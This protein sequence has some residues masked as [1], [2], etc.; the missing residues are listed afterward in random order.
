M[1]IPKSK[2]DQKL[3]RVLLTYVTTTKT[4]QLRTGE[5]KAD[6]RCPNGKTLSLELF[7]DTSWFK[8]RA[9]W[10]KAIWLKK[11]L[12]SE[13][14]CNATSVCTT[15]SYLFQCNLWPSFQSNG[16]LKKWK[17]PSSLKGCWI[18]GELHWCRESYN[19]LLEWAYGC[20]VIKSWP[21]SVSWWLQL[22]C[23]SSCW[24]H[25]WNGYI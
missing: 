22:I 24:V 23:V 13:V 17:I 7:P 16:T 3:T 6:V 9:H 2:I 18:Q 25:N 19:L 21:K 12:P 20:K 14:L 11:L 5:H 8:S 10:L 15:Y 1:G 4:T